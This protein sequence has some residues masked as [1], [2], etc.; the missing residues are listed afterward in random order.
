MRVTTFRRRRLTARFE[1]I[2]SSSV[3]RVHR[4]NMRDAPPVRSPGASFITARHAKK[5]KKKTQHTQLRRHN[6]NRNQ[7]AES[8]RTENHAAVSAGCLSLFLV[9]HIHTMLYVQLQWRGPEP[10]SNTPSQ[11][12]L[13]HAVSP[14]RVSPFSL[15]K[16]TAPKQPPDRSFCTSR[17]ERYATRRFSRRTHQHRGRDD[18]CFPRRRA[19]SPARGGRVSFAVE[20]VVSDDGCNIRTRAVKGAFS[21][22]VLR[23]VSLPLAGVRQAAAPARHAGTTP[24]RRLLAHASV[25]RLVTGRES[26]AALLSFI[27]I[28]RQVDRL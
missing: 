23:A 15:K 6:N 19:S 18:G 10:V 4:H 25:L 8:F 26:A 12:V 17:C 14:Q 21:Y 27:F 20:S 16:T 22:G 5:K 7:L 2:S 1:P 24:P 13:S 11:T 3:C 28:N 9:V